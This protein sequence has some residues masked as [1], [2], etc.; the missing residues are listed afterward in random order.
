[1]DDREPLGMEHRLGSGKLGQLDESN[2][3]PP[4]TGLVFFKP[5]L[6]GR[7]GRS[8]VEQ[9]SFGVEEAVDSRDSLEVGNRDPL[10][11]HVAGCSVMWLKP[12]LT[13]MSRSALSISTAWV[14]QIGRGRSWVLFR[15]RRMVEAL[16]PLIRLNS[17]T[18]NPRELSW[19]RN[20][21]P[22]KT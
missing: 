15:A 4:G 20:T 8:H 19:A 3:I 6:N 22:W 16:T 9:T 11:A 13:G 12:R 18:L 2:L 17:S 7:Y 1:M 5:T 21:S 14:S 10:S